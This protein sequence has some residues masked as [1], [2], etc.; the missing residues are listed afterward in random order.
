MD[1]YHDDDERSF[2][3][4]V[5][6]KR[7]FQK[8]RIHKPLVR[9]N[10]TLK[11][12]R[13][14]RPRQSSDIS[15]IKY[16]LPGETPLHTNVTKREELLLSFMK[17]AKKQHSDRHE[18]KLD[19][20]I[21]DQYKIHSTEQRRRLHVDYPP[22]D[23]Q[24][25]LDVDREYFSCV[26]GRLLPKRR[27]LYKSL[28]SVLSDQLR[29]RQEIG[30]KKDC[31]LNIEYSHRREIKKFNLAVQRYLS[32][33]TQFDTFISEDYHLSMA[34]LG[35]GESLKLRLLELDAERE[36]LANHLFTTTSRLITLDFRY[37][38]QQKYGRF[39]YYLSPPY[40]RSQN[41][42]FARS[43]EIEAR[44]FD[45]GEVSEDD[46]FDIMFSKMKAEFS[47]N[48]TKP[49]LYFKESHDIIEVFGTN[50]QQQLHHLTH[51]MNASPH[52]RSLDKSKKFLKEWTANDSAVL[53]SIISD[54]E[55]HIEFYQERANQLEAKFFQVLNGFFYDC[56]GSPEALKFY[57][58]LEFCYEKVFLETPINMDILG[59]GKA[60][61]SFY[62]DCSK[63]LDAMSNDQ[64]RQAVKQAMK[65]E[66]IKVK[67]C[68]MAA[69]ELRL[70]ERLE[71]ELLLAFAPV[72]NKVLNSMIDESETKLE[73]IKK[74]IKELK[75]KPEVEKKK[76]RP[77][78]ESE[79]EY[80]HLFTDW[81]GDEDPGDYLLGGNYDDDNNETHYK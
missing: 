9:E 51:V 49:V 61:E 71:H 47:G 20:N 17:Y 35:K 12:K 28:K 75:Q 79:V 16:C 65:M 63:R 37:R 33:V 62:F 52:T 34:I 8:T 48:L 44:G 1:P 30:Y 13:E 23:V 46:P 14:K 76:I 4:D 26:D 6:N 21:R 2:N 66:K 72:P 15:L 18:Q 10:R 67:K 40:F 11:I 31:V 45:F 59:M 64:V 68:T 70:F 3:I 32:Q 80:L 39:L 50:A 7:V 27:L 54:F 69:K 55:W 43:V 81:T 57:L 29:I 53:A 58:H 41:R 42:A 36:H 24:T 74:K 73:V 78:N 19:I 38:T 25:I 5:P 60:L 77:L 22:N 56:V